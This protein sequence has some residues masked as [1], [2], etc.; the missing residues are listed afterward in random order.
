MPNFVRLELVVEIRQGLDQ[1]L[2]GND[3]LTKNDLGVGVG[4]TSRVPL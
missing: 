3:A 4:A 1:L 2:L